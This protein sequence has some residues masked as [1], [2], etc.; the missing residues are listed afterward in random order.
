MKRAR[1]RRADNGV[2]PA[3][4]PTPREH[5][6][7]SQQDGRM[8]AVTGAAGG[9]GRAIAERLARDGAHVVIVDVA[10]GTD[11]VAAIEDAGGSAEFRE[12]DVTDATAMNATFAGLELDTLVNN[13]GYYAPLVENKKRFDDIDETEWET[14]MDVNAKGVFLASRAALPRFEGNGSI[15]NIS[16]TTA[17]K[18]TPGFLHYVAS[19]SAVLGMTRAM[20][21]ELGDIGICVNA[22][23]PGFTAS[24]ASKQAG[25][26]YLD[27]RVERQAI[28]RPVQPADVASAVAFLADP[29][30][31]MVTGQ[32]LTIDGGKTMY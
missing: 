18:G 32:A 21:T 11:A 6:D 13:A 25:E 19:K 17:V 15:V 8:A 24:D 30:S 28:Q 3:F 16:S 10:D 7:M 23:L 12:G 22:V 4:I 14:V 20:A 26:E 31:E 9:I 1:A 2:M 5:S 27:T 29:D